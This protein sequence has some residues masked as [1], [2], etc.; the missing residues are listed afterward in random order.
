MVCQYDNQWSSYR[1]NALEQIDDLV[2]PILSFTAW[3]RMTVCVK[4]LIERCSISQFPKP[5]LTK[6]ER[7]LTKHGHWVTAASR[8]AFNYN[9]R[10]G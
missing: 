3:G 9:W 5:K 4:R 10:G 1:F 6:L 7:R 2:I 8:N